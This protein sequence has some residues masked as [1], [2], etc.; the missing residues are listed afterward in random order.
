M[1]GPASSSAPWS[2]CRRSC[3]GRGL[4]QPLLGTILSRSGLCLHCAHYNQRI[5]L[6][7]P[8]SSAHSVSPPG[9]T[10][11][12]GWLVHQGQQQDNRSQH[13][14]ADM[15][16]HGRNRRIDTTSATRSPA[17]HQYTS[18]RRPLLHF[19]RFSM[20][21]FN[22]KTCQVA[23]ICNEL[24]YLLHPQILV[25]WKSKQLVGLLEMPACPHL[26]KGASEF[27]ELLPW[28]RLGFL[29]EI[30]AGTHLEASHEQFKNVGLAEDAA[31]WQPNFAN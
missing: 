7:M 18:A 21:A 25:S 17:F 10:L 26:R 13:G 15:G 30:P 11:R 12:Y 2:I 31:L 22:A 23:P 20:P 19:S 24:I 4:Q 5:F 27:D 9:C 28:V 3:L 8:S 14:I 16:K 6:L 1:A 29:A